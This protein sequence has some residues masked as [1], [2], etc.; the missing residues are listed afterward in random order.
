VTAVGEH[1]ARGQRVH[2]E[3]ILVPDPDV[4]DHRV[5]Q[6]ADTVDDHSPAEA[7]RR[8]ARRGGGLAD[9][10]ARAGTRP[11]HLDVRRRSG[12]GPSMDPAGKTV[13]ITGATS[14]LGQAAAIHFA[15]RGAKVIVVGR[16]PTRAEETRQAA[17]E[18]AEI[19]LGD[20]STRSGALSVARSLLAGH[21]RV[22]VLLNNAGGQFASLTRTADDIE[23][24]FALNTFGAFVLER[25]LHGALVAAKGRVVNV[26][27]GLLDWFPVDPADLV[28][29]RKFSGMSQY[30]RTKQA[31]VMMTVEQAE[32]FT[33]EGVTVVSVHPGIIMGTRFNGGQPKFVQMV[34]GPIM[35]AL[36]AA[37]TLEEA[38]RRFEVACFGDVPTGSYL[39]NGKVA[40]LPKQVADAAVRAR[41]FAL[42]ESLAA[43]A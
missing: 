33:A 37:C 39:V 4:D 29:P 20:V 27:T 6:A 19:V 38:T 42:L 9:P 2:A 3:P 12:Y 13:V 22:D 31:S 23:S 16:D 30:G 18:N 28:A 10:G 14:G 17:G 26:A 21:P 15:G 32:R 40:A 25:A 36:G 1:P 11:E 24:T 7:E 34:G 41:V 8:A 5:L 35:R 43:A